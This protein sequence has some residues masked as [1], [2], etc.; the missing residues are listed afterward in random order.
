VTEVLQDGVEL[1]RAPPV[2]ARAPLGPPVGQQN[3]GGHGDRQPPRDGPLAA[4][5]AK[6]ELPIDSVSRIYRENEG[7]IQLAFKRTLLPNRASK[8]ASMRE[9]ALLTA[10]GRQGAEIEVSTPFAAMREECRA[11]GVLDSPNFAGE[12]GKLDFR[13]TGGRND[14]QASVLRH[15]YEDAAMLIGRMVGG[16]GS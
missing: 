2:A 8:A 10:V 1:L 5:A 7:Q 6:L 16:T 12:I 3:G 14:R 4:I 13:L 11:Y 9:V 15:H